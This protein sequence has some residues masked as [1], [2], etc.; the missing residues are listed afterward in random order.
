ML[1]AE[2]TMVPAEEVLCLEKGELYIGRNSLDDGYKIENKIAMLENKEI[3]ESFPVENLRCVYVSG[4]DEDGNSRYVEFIIPEIFMTIYGDAENKVELGD[5]PHTQF[6][7]ENWEISN[8]EVNFTESDLE[9][10]KD[11][12]KSMDYMEK[13]Q[14]GE[15]KAFRLKDETY[16][17]IMKHR[18]KVGDFR[19]KLESL[20][21]FKLSFILKYG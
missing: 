17:E 5:T 4:K 8:K 1:S 11:L 2:K 3:G 15:I 14:E 16:N 13:V 19:D 18:K 21:E 7:I 9:F 20:T 10:F 6:L 12:K